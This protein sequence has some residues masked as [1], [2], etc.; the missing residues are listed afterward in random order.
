MYA[1]SALGG[2]TFQTLLKKKKSTVHVYSTKLAVVYW[3]RVIMI[4][5]L[6][7]RGLVQYFVTNKQET[8][9]NVWFATLIS[10]AMS[11]FTF[12]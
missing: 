7:E 2:D 6:K 5:V 12:L 8:V 3:T 11:R 1:G 10:N 4:G 9:G